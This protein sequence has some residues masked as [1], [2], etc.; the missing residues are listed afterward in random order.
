MRLAFHKRPRAHPPNGAL[1]V[2]KDRPHKGAYDE[3]LA[4][5]C[6]IENPI[7]K[8]PSLLRTVYAN[9]LLHTLFSAH[10]LEELGIACRLLFLRGPAQRVGAYVAVDCFEIPEARV[11]W[12]LELGSR[13][14]G[15]SN[16]VR[17]AGQSHA[18]GTVALSQCWRGLAHTSGDRRHHLMRTSIEDSEKLTANP[19]KP[20]IRLP[21][22]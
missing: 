20:P 19:M 10:T 2:S 18:W 7:F 1:H 17:P 13:N 5:A 11:G 4:R 9:R 6:V 22:L 15:Q 16:R 8:T 21:P 12:I 14:S 3:K